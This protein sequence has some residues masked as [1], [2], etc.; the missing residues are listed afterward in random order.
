MRE[1]V[2]E[3]QPFVREEHSIEEALAL[4]ADQPYKREIIEGVRAAAGGAAVDAELAG[5]APS[6]AS[7]VSAYRNTERFVDL[8]RGPARALDRPARP[9]QADA[10]RRRLLARRRE[11]P[12]AAAHLRHRVGVEGGPRRAPPPLGGGRA[13][14]PPQ[15]R[16]WSSTSSPS[17]RRSA[18]ASPCSTRRAGIIRRLMEDYSRRRHEEAGYEF[19]NTPHITKAELFEISGHLDWYADG[20]YP[21]MELDGGQRLLPQA[22]ELPVPHPDLQEPAALVPRAAAAPVRVRHGLPL[23]EVRRGARAH[24]RARASRRTTRTSSA[25]REQLAG[26]LDS[27]LDLRPR[28]AARLRPRRL[29]PRAVDASRRASP[30]A[31]TRS[32]TRPPRRCGGPR[33]SRELDL[34]LDEGG[35]AF[36]GPK[37][38]VQARDAIGRTWQ[39]STIQL[40]FQL[41]QRFELSLHRRRQRAGTGRS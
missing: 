35:G 30:S 14:R 28:P 37:I 39:M 29:L 10:R 13:A 26:E 9:L 38:S 16:R 18:R 33:E 20:M 17:P 25:P 19:V 36:Y 23:R 27:L 5:E 3:D 8:C 1:I 4:F 15:A 40:D 34:V 24:P 32:G 2:A 31:P 7:A 6:G 11:E 12:P 21:P 22:D 41:P